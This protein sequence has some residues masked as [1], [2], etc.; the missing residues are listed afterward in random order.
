MIDF[1]AL[2]VVADDQRMLGKMLK[3]LVNEGVRVSSIGQT[4]DCVR[5]VTC[6]NKDGELGVGQADT[7]GAS[8]ERAYTNLG[9][10]LRGEIEVGG[11]FVSRVEMDAAAKSCRRLQ[12]EMMEWARRLTS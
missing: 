4:A 7:P 8:I 2:T 5:W 10:K 1:K 6:I 9:R 12:W 11:Q 3:L